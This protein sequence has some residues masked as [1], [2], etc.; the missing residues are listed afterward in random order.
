MLQALGTIFFLGG[1]MRKLFLFIALI[2]IATFANTAKAHWFQAD[3]RCTVNAAYAQCSVT[4]TLPVMIE[5]AGSI[6]ARTYY[7]YY[8]WVNVPNLFVEPGQYRYIYLRAAN[9]NAD[10]IVWANMKMQCRTL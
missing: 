10:P 5:C 2:V 4:N 8:G 6:E 7:G 9:P 1:R 3:S